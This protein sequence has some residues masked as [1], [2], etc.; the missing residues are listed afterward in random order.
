MKELVSYFQD[1]KVKSVL[2][3]GCGGGGEEEPSDEVT[4]QTQATPPAPS[5][6]AADEEAVAGAER[7]D[8]ARLGGRGVLPGD[9]LSLPHPPARREVGTAPH[10][11]ALR[12]AHR[13]PSVS[14]A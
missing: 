13:P 5:A 6:T 12:L 7:D 9:R 1:K 11:R 10:G 3:V 2:D 4:T 8:L 14:R